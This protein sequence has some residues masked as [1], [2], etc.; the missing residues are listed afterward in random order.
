MSWERSEQDRRLH[1]MVRVGRV[2]EVDAAR[3]RARVNLGGDTLSDWLPWTAARAGAI[4][5]WAPPG[6]GEQVVVIS[7][8][9]ESAQGVITG[10][11]YQAAAP[12]PAQHGQ[13]WG[14]KIGTSFL[15]MTAE[16][17]TLAAGGSTL[18]IDAGGIRLN[19]A[20]IDLN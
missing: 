3:A 1:G 13:M 14:M 20:K 9:G 12:A 16:N 19:G 15:T 5:E 2:V 4:K 10:A 7:P 18:V 8:G 6:V 11:I 17:I